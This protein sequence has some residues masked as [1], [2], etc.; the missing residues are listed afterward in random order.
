M[1]KRHLNDLVFAFLAF[2]L[3]IGGCGKGEREELKMV[4]VSGSNGYFS[5][6]SLPKYQDYLQNNCENLQVTLLQASGELNEKDE[7]S[8]IE[9]LEALSNCDV[10]LFFTR[11]VTIDGEQLEMVKEYV[12]SGNPV[13]AI[14]TASHGFQNW[15]EFDSLVLGGNYHGLYEG[16]P[17]EHVMDSISGRTTPKGEPE[18][19]IMEV[20]VNPDFQDHPVLTGID[21]FKSRYSL[22]KNK[23]L[24]S[25]VNILMRG[26][27][28]DTITEPV[29]WTRKYK[30]ANVL[31]TAL[32]GIRDFENPVFKKLVTN[33]LF[34]AANEEQ[35]IKK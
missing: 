2:A 14:R 25:D 3:L 17:E 29:V 10:A 24:A 11:R 32:G 21:D 34:W 23:P 18:G 26:T 35:R 9:G 5:H 33:A 8:E 27:I 4:F 31:Y 30:G 20:Q 15:L 12:N 6:V 16:N 13:V 22:Y 19:P 28:K 1:C 7:L